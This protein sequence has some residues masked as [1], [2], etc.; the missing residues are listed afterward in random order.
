MYNSDQKE[1]FLSTQV[2]S[3]EKIRVEKMFEQI[4][5][6]EKKY[7]CDVSVFKSKTQRDAAIRH[8]KGKT[9]EMR[10][11]ITS[12]RKYIK[13]CANERYISKVDLIANPFAVTIPYTEFVS[14]FVVT[15]RNSVKSSKQLDNM[16]RQTL[17][18]DRQGT[19]DIRAKT[20]IYLMYMGFDYKQIS[21]IKL[22]DYNP[23]KNVI[24]GVQI[25]AAFQQTLYFYSRLKEETRFRLYK[26]GGLVEMTYPLEDNGMFFRN[27]EGAKGE[28]SHAL[29]NQINELNK[30]LSKTTGINWDF[31][32]KS[33]NRNGKFEVFHELDRDM[34]NLGRR[35]IFDKYIKMFMFAGAPAVFVENYLCWLKFYFPRELKKN[36]EYGMPVRDYKY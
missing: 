6:T 20:A 14:M 8:M 25:P 9:E 11:Y 26:M 10:I 17:R 33:L 3:N 34:P 30:A 5:V 4:S 28:S 24:A 27:K 29:V 13:W 1:K 23:D 36:D 31:S 21:E 2:P 18:P 32:C 22:S 16:M 35:D 19:V 7:R 12:L 15:Y